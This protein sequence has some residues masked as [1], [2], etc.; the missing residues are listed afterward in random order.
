MLVFQKRHPSETAK[1]KYKQE[2]PPGR[3]SISMTMCGYGF[4][5][6]NP[7]HLEKTIISDTLRSS[8]REKSNLAPLQLYH[9]LLF[10]L[11]SS[12]NLQGVRC[13]QQRP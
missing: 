6:H 9:P 3:C 10:K 1:P 12:P 13:S 11:Y 5:Q 4:A 7:T 8:F 2:V